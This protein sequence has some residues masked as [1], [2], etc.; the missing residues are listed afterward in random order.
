M[1]NIVLRKF[2]SIKVV[3]AI[4]MTKVKKVMREGH[5]VSSGLGDC[6]LV[7]FLEVMDGMILLETY[8][9]QPPQ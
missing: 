8:C 5:L 7:R 3:K 2:E 9:Y 6:E 4:R 1:R